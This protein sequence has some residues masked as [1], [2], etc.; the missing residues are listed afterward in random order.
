VKFTCCN[1]NHLKNT[2]QCPLVH[3][4]CSG[5]FYGGPA[6]S[7]HPKKKPIPT[8]SHCFPSDYQDAVCLHTGCASQ[9]QNLKLFFA[10]LGFELRTYTLSHSTNPFLWWVFFKIGSRENYLPRILNYL[11]KQDNMLSAYL[12]SRTI[13]L[14]WPWTAILLIS[15]SWVGLQ[16]WATG[17]WLKIWNCWAPRRCH[18]LGTGGSRL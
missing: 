5:T 6:L 18:M 16:V 13:C 8:G 10:A 17:A 11:E 4:L 1:I 7:H 15:A 12:L 14:G 3:L 9:I 2:T